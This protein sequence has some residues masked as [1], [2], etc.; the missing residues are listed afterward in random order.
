[1]NPQGWAL[2]SA[3]GQCAR[4]TLFHTLCWTFALASPRPRG[5]SRPPR[6]CPPAEKGDLESRLN[7]ASSVVQQMAAEKAAMLAEIERLRMQVAAVSTGAPLAPGAA[8][9]PLAKRLPP[10]AKRL[11]PLAEPASCDGAGAGR[12]PPLI[13]QAQ[14]MA[15]KLVSALWE[16]K[17]AGRRHQAR[18]LRRRLRKPPSPRLLCHR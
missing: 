4:S 3:P 10:L 18:P 2:G 6:R 11:P 5:P 15:A 17:E 12:R 16:G 1:M 13:E 9:P 14:R 8:P 7:Q